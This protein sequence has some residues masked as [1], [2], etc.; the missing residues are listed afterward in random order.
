MTDLSRDDFAYAY[1]LRVRYAET[2]MQAIVFYGNYMVYY[3]TAITEYLRSLG[4]DYQAYITASGNDFH[5]VRTTLEYLGSAVFDDWLDICV[6]TGRVGNSS[7]NFEVA[8]FV[9]GRADA[10]NR[11]EVLWVNTDQSAHK[12]TPVPDALRD[13]IRKLEGDRPFA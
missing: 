6:R 10:I 3:D 5:V 7:L 8:T 9:D 4:W 1:R 11:G 12:S 13:A 2:D